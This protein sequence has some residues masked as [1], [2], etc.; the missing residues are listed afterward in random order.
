M[1]KT[2]VLATSIFL[3]TVHAAAAAT[4]PTVTTTPASSVTSS[5]A[6]LNG[7]INPNGSSTT[8]YFEYG[9]TM[10][11]GSKTAVQNAGSGT[12]SVNVSA[13]VSGLQGNHSFHFR[14]VASSAGGSSQG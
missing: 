1:K 6:T 4:A 14:L 3:I 12:S 10:G 8:W 2:L 5:S 7:S 11:Y 9:Q 13:P